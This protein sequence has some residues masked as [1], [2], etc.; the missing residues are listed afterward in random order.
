MSEETKAPQGS[1]GK[2]G[3]SVKSAQKRKFTSAL[4][5]PFKQFK[6]GIYV[7]LIS[8]V[9]TGL[10][11]FLFILAFWQQYLHVMN[12]FEVVGPAMQW[13]MMTNEV[14]RTN[15]IKVSV[16]FSAFVLV[17]MAVVFK[18]T[19]N[20]YGPLVS[21]ERFVDLVAGGEYHQRISVRKTDELSRLAGKLNHMAEQLETRHQERE[22][23]A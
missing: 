5:E 7:I 10:A 20:Y 6:I 14:F 17:I 2:Q 16:L 12:I 18:V 1:T 21:I 13:E 3:T 11:L 9:F 15:I 4:I 22:T 8:F 23:S 19:H